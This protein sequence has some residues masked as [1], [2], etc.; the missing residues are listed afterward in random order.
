MFQSSVL[1]T[2][3]NFTINAI[4]KTFTSIAFAASVLAQVAHGHCM[5]ITWHGKRIIR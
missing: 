1:A 5:L 4:M 2:L 3:S